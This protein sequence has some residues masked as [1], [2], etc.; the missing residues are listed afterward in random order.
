[1][2]ID[3]RPVLAGMLL[4]LAACGGGGGSGSSPDTPPADGTV[5]VPTAI[6]A[7]P[8][9]AGSQLTADNY[10]SFA[11]PLAR[12]VLNATGDSL[13]GTTLGNGSVGTASAAARAGAQ[14]AR[15]G[16]DGRARPEAIATE[17]SPCTNGGSLT[18]SANDADGNSILSIGDALTLTA[19]H[20]VISLGATPTDGGFTITIKAIELDSGNNATALDGTGGLNAFSVGSDAHLS[21]SFELWAKQ[22]SA[23]SKL[24]RLSYANVS[25]VF[26]SDTV[27]YN[28]DIDT[29][30]TG[31][32]A[33]Y[34]MN[35]NFWVSGQAYKMVQKTAFPV[36][37]SDE[38]T[39]G[40]IT[41]QDVSGAT[42][43]LTARS[44]GLLDFAFFPPGSTTPSST[45]TD[46]TWD[47]FRSAP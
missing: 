27:L 30:V 26:G 25:S 17:T 1:M 28:F 16:A 8:A 13:V 6:R 41:L 33:T 37:T 2:Q 23:S 3:T 7:E 11:G 4:S 12:A 32:S 10:A 43:Q 29:T 31:N 20:C 42:L 45:L 44:G 34:A 38:P 22:E 35:G 14:S 19:D 40:A 47:S 36:T 24:L 21:G 18:V 9:S 39:A 15:H 46:Q 5:T